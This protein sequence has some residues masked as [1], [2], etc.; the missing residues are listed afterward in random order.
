VLRPFP[1]ANGLVARAAEHALLVA[2]G[3][4]PLSVTVP[5]VGH[6]ELAGSYAQGLREYAGGGLAGVQAWLLRSCEVMAL[7]AERSPLSRSVQ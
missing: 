4:D 3:I 1:V 5:E 6:F 7:S 2:R